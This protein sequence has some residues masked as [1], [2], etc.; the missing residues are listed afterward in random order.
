MRRSN[1]DLAVGNHIYVGMLPNP[2]PNLAQTVLS[3]S[4][5]LCG[6]RGFFSIRDAPLKAYF[7][8]A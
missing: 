6:N 8:L 3:M 4:A 7:F 1:A 5:I 2:K